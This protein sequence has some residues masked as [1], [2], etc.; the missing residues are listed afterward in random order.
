MNVRAFSH[1]KCSEGL[2]HSL[3][4]A[5]IVLFKCS[6]H[7]IL[8]LSFYRSLSPLSPYLSFVLS[9]TH[10][11]SLIHSLTHSLILSL[12]PPRH[13]SLPSSLSHTRQQPH[14]TNF[15]FSI[16]ATTTASTF[17][18]RLVCQRGNPFTT[19]LVPRQHPSSALQSLCYSSHYRPVFFFSIFNIFRSFIF[20]FHRVPRH[21]V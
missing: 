13:P 4:F 14:L 8:S 6:H 5:L 15:L 16:R 1:E 10:T 11:H 19:L 9:Q 21:V 12:S 3:S 20:Y 18:H 7:P 2:S 17:K